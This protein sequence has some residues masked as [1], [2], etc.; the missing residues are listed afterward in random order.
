MP[1]SGHPGRGIPRQAGV[2]A[3]TALKVHRSRGELRRGES[4][5]LD[6]RRP[7]PHLHAQDR[8]EAVDHR[9]GR[10]GPANDRQHQVLHQHCRTGY[11]GYFPLEAL[12]IR[13]VPPLADAHLDHAQGASNPAGE[14][15]PVDALVGHHPSLRQV[16]RPQPGVKQADRARTVWIPAELLPHPVLQRVERLVVGPIHPEDPHAPAPARAPPLE[17]FA[18][19]GAQ[20]IVGDLQQSDRTARPERRPPSGRHV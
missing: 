15:P 18:D 3:G 1:R 6:R 16:L 10:L 9:P 12:Q 11:R 4:E 14:R 2:A 5:I 8:L 20:R 7:H 19:P 17:L 13:I